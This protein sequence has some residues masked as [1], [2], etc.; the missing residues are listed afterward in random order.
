MRFMMMAKSAENGGVPPRELMEAMGKLMAQEAKEGKIVAGGGLAPM[1]TS[2]GC[3]FQ[4]ESWQCLT[5]RSPRRKRLWAD[6]R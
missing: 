5:D 2:R 3:G 1:A 6:M 4:A